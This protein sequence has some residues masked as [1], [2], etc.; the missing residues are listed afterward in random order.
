M[1]NVINSDKLTEN[2]PISASEAAEIT[3]HGGSVSRY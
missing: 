2:F 1:V 3:L